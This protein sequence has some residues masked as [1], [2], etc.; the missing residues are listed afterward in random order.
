M[1]Q[2]HPEVVIEK[3][4][5]L[6]QLL[7][8]IE[9]GEALTEI[10]AELDL[11]VSPT[12]LTTWQ[13]KYEA[14]GRSWEALVD[15]RYGHEQ[16]ITSEMKAWLYERKREEAGLTGPDLVQELAERFKVKISEGHVNHLLRQVGLSRPPGRPP[17]PSQ[18]KAETTSDPAGPVVDQAGLFFPGGR[19]GGAGGGGS[20][21]RECGHSPAGVSSGQSGDFGAIAD[22]WAGHDLE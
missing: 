11:E 5:R 15:G 4:Q 20:G 21:D 16:I 6:E 7:Q 10:C 22:E 9:Q 13:A 19:Q 18:P 17:K 3:A 12:R 2:P 8:R 1:N 14:G